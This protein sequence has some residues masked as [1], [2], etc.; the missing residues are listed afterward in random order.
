MTNQS[1]TV[2]AAP[3]APSDPDP[4]LLHKEFNEIT[5]EQNSGAWDYKG[6]P[7]DKAA[8]EKHEEYVRSRVKRGIE[9][10]AILRRSNTGPAKAKP[11]KRGKPAIDLVAAAASLLE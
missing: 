5:V 7:N 10:V 8:I 2:P 6:D 4:A 11:A 3:A 9:L 1:P